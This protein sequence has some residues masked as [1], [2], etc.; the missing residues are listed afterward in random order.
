[1]DPK[2]MKFFLIGTGFAAALGLL[3]V[4]GMQQP[5]G[6]A[7][8]LTVSEFLAAPDRAAD[9]FRVNGKVADG[10]I[11]RLASGQDVRFTITDGATTMPVIYHGVIPDTFVDGAEVVVEGRLQNDGT[12][13]AHTL[14]AKCPSKYEAGEEAPAAGLEA[15]HQPAGVGGEN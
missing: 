14:L 2:R 12:F 3:I 1:M 8:Y 6:F 5:G 9:G 11:T 10:T 13:S 4:A 7:Y 15:S